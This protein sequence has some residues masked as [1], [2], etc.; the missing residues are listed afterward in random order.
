MNEICKRCG[1][2]HSRIAYCGSRKT[3][4]YLMTTHPAPAQYEELR[5]RIQHLAD[6]WP[7]RYYSNPSDFER[8]VLEGYKRAA[9]E[10]LAA[11]REGK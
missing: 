8:G 6:T 7:L 5:E 2:D 4:K 3:A 10:L 9:N 1:A 11:L